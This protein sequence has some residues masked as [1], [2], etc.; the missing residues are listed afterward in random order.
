MQVSPPTRDDVTNDSKWTTLVQK[1]FPFVLNEGR[2]DKI[3]GSSIVYQDYIGVVGKAVDPCS[4]ELL[5]LDS[6]L[7]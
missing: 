1:L 4:A 3:K 7:A 2:V 6:S 5:R